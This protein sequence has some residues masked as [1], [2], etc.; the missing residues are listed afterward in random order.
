MSQ[1]GAIEIKAVTEETL[2]AWCHAVNVGFLRA[3]APLAEEVRRQRLFPGR[4]LGAFEGERVVATLR[5][6][7]LQLT[8]PG[9]ASLAASAVT[10]VT[11][12]QTH[13]RRGLLTR[14]MRQDLAAAKDR[15]EAVAILIAAEYGIY[16][17]FGFGPA[18][19][20]VGRKIDLKRAGG[21]RAE[22]AGAV[23]GRLDLVSMAELGKLGPE[24]HERWRR[25]QPG[26]INRDE[27]HW[28]TVT[29]EL[30][31][32]VS[33]GWKEPFAVA[34]RDAAGQ[35]TGLAV[36]QV[37]SDWDGVVP[38]GTV[39]VKDFLALDLPTAVSLWRYLTEVDWTTKV[40]VE[41][42]GPDDPLP[43]LLTDPRAATITETADFTW[44]RVLDVPTAFAARR[45]AAAG[46]VVL[47]VTDPD[48][49]AAGRWA[50][51]ADQEGAGRAV[52]T[53]DEPDLALSASALGSLYLGAESASRL[54]AAGLVEECRPGAAFA[55]DQ[56][57]TTPLKAWN[58][59]SF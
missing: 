48:G 15:G 55:A 10:A 41:N 43:L 8:L 1:D 29:G 34:H 4:T 33:D 3:G 6:F 17:R 18:T 2:S 13:R 57:L 19:R 52:R 16:G 31:L 42:L 7:P 11:T 36:Y 35:V 56:L 30:V 39:Q 9:G 59:D 21:I 40:V 50:L 49:F 14:M 25:Q 37:K 47:E 26:A 28:K 12:T 45:Y 53:E 44:L 46:R 32:P 27:Q 5:S 38:D 54:A 22:L 58:P 20:M 24:L 23:G 51:E